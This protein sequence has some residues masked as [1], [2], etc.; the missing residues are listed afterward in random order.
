MTNKKTLFVY[1]YFN[2]I[3]DGKSSYV[4]DA[5][6]NFPNANNQKV[7]VEIQGSS[8]SVT[9][10]PNPFVPVIT[11]NGGTLVFKNDVNAVNTVKTIGGTVIRIILAGGA[12]GTTITGNL[13]IYDVV[14]NL[15]NQGKSGDNMLTE[16]NA[17]N[18]TVA[19]IAYDIYWNGL[20]SKGMKVAPGGYMGIIYLNTTKNGQTQKS[21]LV[22]KIGIKR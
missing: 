16:N 22:C 19:T 8:G 11:Q 10:G 17:S 18:D 1:E 2:I 14:G 15:V 6:G 9:V 20:N 3:S 13:K 5:A 4:A 21:K 7:H 12:S